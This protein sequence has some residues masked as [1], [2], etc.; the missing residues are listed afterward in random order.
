MRYTIPQTS[1][2]RRSSGTC[3]CDLYWFIN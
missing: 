3:I 2:N 1:Q